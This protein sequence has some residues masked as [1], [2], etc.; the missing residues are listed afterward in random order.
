MNRLFP[1]IGSFLLLASA[2]AVVAAAIANTRSFPDPSPATVER[3]LPGGASALSD[4]EIP[5]RPSDDVYQII[6][7]RPL[8]DPTRRPAIELPDAAPEPIPEPSAARQPDLPPDVVLYGVL[9]S[10]GHLRALVRFENTE[11]AWIE[12]GTSLGG[13]RVEEIHLNWIVLTRAGANLRIDLSKQ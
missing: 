13:W 2:G 1:L 10:S 4:T 8:F 6:L 12:T 7:E 3:R 5:S 11:L 9:G